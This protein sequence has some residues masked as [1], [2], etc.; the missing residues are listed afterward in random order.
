M[1]I[2]YKN[3]F[4]IAIKN[5]E[6]IHKIKTGICPKL[7]YLQYFICLEKLTTANLKQVSIGSFMYLFFIAH[8]LRIQNVFIFYNN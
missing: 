3:I 5:D 4:H 2:I 6:L 8:V 1:K 7:I